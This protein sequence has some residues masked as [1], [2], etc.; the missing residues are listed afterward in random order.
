MLPEKESKLVREYLCESLATSFFMRQMMA[1]DPPAKKRLIDEINQIVM[2]L[3][4]LVKE[5]RYIKPL[6][7]EK[8]FDIQECSV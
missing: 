2:R 8:S 4:E 6:L 7:K 1:D 5:W 3:P